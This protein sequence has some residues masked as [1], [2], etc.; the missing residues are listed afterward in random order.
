MTL[1]TVHR[2]LILAAMFLGLLLVAFS[3]YRFFGQGEK[4]YLPTGVLGGIM[5]VGLFFYYRWFMKKK[6]A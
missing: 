3:L 5:A 4:A 2:I 1:K 6:T